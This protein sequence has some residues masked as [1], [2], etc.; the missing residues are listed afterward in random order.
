MVDGFTLELAFPEW[1]IETE[2]KMG[3]TQKQIAQTYAMALVIRSEKPD[4][5]RINNAITA[6]WPKGLERVKKMAW[7]IFEQKRKEYIERKKAEAKR[8]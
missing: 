5:L 3:M 6:R 8:G 7:K 4:W 2:I 1:V